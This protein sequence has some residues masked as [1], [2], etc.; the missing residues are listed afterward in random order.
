[1]PHVLGV[2]A[3]SF[4]MLN[5]STAQRRFAWPRE[6]LQPVPVERSPIWDHPEVGFGEPE[7]DPYGYGP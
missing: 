6:A 5:G 1:M 2:S 4:A 7:R 3:H